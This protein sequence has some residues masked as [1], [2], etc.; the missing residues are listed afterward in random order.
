MFFV[1]KVFYHLTAFW[2]RRGLEDLGYASAQEQD[3]SLLELCGD[4]VNCIA[5][6]HPKPNKSSEV[7]IDNLNDFEPSW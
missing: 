7:D 2:S 3:L 4:I 1:F 5:A 6:H